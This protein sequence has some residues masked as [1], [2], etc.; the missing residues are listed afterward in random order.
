MSAFVHGQKVTKVSP[1]ILDEVKEASVFKK[2][3]K[4]NG[5]ATL[6]NLNRYHNW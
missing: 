3:Y 1:A 6:E 2:Y 4:E 5:I